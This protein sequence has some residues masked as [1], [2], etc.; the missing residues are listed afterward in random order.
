M[1]TGENNFSFM[2]YFNR[3]MKKI[4]DSTM[5]PAPIFLG[6]LAACF[7][8]TFLGISESLVTT[9][10]ATVFPIFWSI[11]A[12]ESPDTDDDKQW[13][14]YWVVISAFQIIDDY[15]HFILA[16]IPLYYFLKLVLI[17]ILMLPNIQGSAW[18]YNTI[19]YRLFKT[20]EK[21]LDNLTEKVANTATN[22]KDQGAR[23]VQENKAAIISGA[24]KTAT[25]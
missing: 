22:L 3:H 10:V 1:S 13:L 6:G 15:S 18:V 24:M 17:V 11:K 14:T 4:S 12:I 21:D 20:Y 7:V 19:V 8:L 23:L 5:L 16:I 25:Q 9:L 2:E